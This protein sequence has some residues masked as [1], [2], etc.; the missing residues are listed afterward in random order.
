VLKPIKSAGALTIAN[1]FKRA[2]DF[3]L[4]MLE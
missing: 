3:H 2:G 1:G 4:N